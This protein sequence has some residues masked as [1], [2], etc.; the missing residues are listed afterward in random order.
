M[1]KHHP[2]VKLIKQWVTFFDK[3][4]FQQVFLEDILSQLKNLD[5]IKAS[6][7]GSIPVKILT[8]HYDL[9]ALLVQLFMNENKDTSK[10]PIELKKGDITSLFKNCDAFAKKITVL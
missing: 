7:F 1:Y 9:F 8:E 5:P 10:C 3:V 4:S 6:P 2:S